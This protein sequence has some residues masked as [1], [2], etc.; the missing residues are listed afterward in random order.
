MALQPERAP[1]LFL[2]IRRKLNHTLI[3][4]VLVPLLTIAM[5]LLLILIAINPNTWRQAAHPVRDAS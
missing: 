4:I 2:D 5:M 1:P 3:M